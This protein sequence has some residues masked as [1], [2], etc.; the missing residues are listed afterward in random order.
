MHSDDDGPLG[1]LLGEW[2]GEG[3]G[4]WGGF[5]FE[6]TL[7][8]ARRGKPWIEFRQLTK[9]AGDTSHAECGYLMVDP[10]GGARMTVAEPSGITEVLSGTVEGQQIALRSDVVGLA[11]GAKNVT[12]TAR[13]FSLEG[14]RL[15]VEVDVAMNDEALAPHTRS[16]L[17]RI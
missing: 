4:L 17:R 10:D 16:V 8:F 12:A 5:L 9:G 13:R 6:D 7:T 1:F 11:P 15:V 14:D 2:A 3:T